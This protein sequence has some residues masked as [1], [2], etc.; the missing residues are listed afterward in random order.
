LRKD[1]LQPIFLTCLLLVHLSS[2]V[3][4]VSWRPVEKISKKSKSTSNNLTCLPKKTSPV[5]KISAMHVKTT[6]EVM[7][8]SYRWNVTF[9]WSLWQT[10]VGSG[11]ELWDEAGCMILAVSFS[12]LKTFFKQSIKIISQNI[13]FLIKLLPWSPPRTT[14]HHHVTAN[15]TVPIMGSL[16]KFSPENL[17]M[18]ENILCLELSPLNNPFAKT[19]F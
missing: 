16:S 8:S 6:N 15:I 5:A 2:K 12:S 14:Y 11:E 9:F 19:L 1:W 13:N 3:R 7:K 10:G 18:S 4:Q 17:S